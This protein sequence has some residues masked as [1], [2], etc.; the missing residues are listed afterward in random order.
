MRK[1]SDTIGTDKVI[2][3]NLKTLMSML[4]CGRTTAEKIAKEAGAVRKIGRRTIY[5][6]AP[7]NSYLESIEG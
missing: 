5:L 7:I 1:T 6:I 4:G 3:V 2:S